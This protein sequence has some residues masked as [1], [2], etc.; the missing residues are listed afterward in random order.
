MKKAI[1]F[2]WETRASATKKNKLGSNQDTGSR[3]GATAGNNLD[4]FSDLIRK[5]VVQNGTK[6]LDVHERQKLVTLPGHFR[7]SKKWDIVI[8]HHGKLLAALELKSLGGPSF[9]NNFN[10]RCEEAIG[11]GLDFKT[12]QREGAFGKGAAPFLGFFILIHDAEKSRK[13]SA[14]P[15]IN[16]AF[17]C[18]QI[19]EGSSY[20]T[21]MATLCERLIQEGIY[22][23]AATMSSPDSAARSGEFSDL[24]DSASFHRFLNKLL[25]HIQAETSII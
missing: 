5:L 18:D 16:E 13:I 15:K 22:T 12:A 23:S 8:M 11:S 7:P 14:K 20:Q 2:F 21:R 4:G 10:N 9:G 1:R 17:E 19:F 25:A 6:D 24:S 3:G